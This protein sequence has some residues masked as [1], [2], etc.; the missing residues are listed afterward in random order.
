[1]IFF[2]IRHTKSPHLGLLQMLEHRDRVQELQGCGTTE[3]GYGTTETGCRGGNRFVKGI[4]K[5][6]EKGD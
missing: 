6:D 5:F 1:M 2:G 4:Q 3:T